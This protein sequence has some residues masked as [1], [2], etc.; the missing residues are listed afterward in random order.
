[1][2][3]RHMVPSVEDAANQYAGTEYMRDIW[4]SFCGC[5]DRCY[6]CASCCS[7]AA[8]VDAAALALDMA[9]SV[10]RQFDRAEQQRRWQAREDAALTASVAW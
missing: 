3:T 5:R 2:N 7:A 6:Q 1:M 8:V 4:A 10:G 9:L